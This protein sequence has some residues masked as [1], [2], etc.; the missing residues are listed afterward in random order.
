MFPD[1][2]SE[3]VSFSQD[4]WYDTLK[5]VLAPIMKRHLVDIT[6]EGRENIPSHGPALLVINHRTTTD[7]FILGAIV[8]RRIHFVVAAFMSRL[9]LTARVVKGTGQIMLP[10]S[11]GGGS[12]KLIEKAKRLLLRGRL[13]GVFPEG[14]D[15]FVNASAPGTVSPFHSSF[16]HL[17][18]GMKI[19]DLP[20]V[21][22]AVTGEE[23]EV[24]IELPKVAMRALD[25][26]WK[27]NSVKAT[28]FRQAH[29]RIGKPLAFDNFY[30]L[31]E[32][33]YDEAVKRIV[34]V[35]HDEVLALAAAPTTLSRRVPS[36]KALT[37]HFDETDL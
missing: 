11:K 13:V 1:F 16:A 7:P 36:K 15:N 35:V 12:K 26:T 23:E 20:V 32:A 29:V 5:T 4:L 2:R 34:S 28:I 37:L 22:I 17:L 9:P 33:R 31:P 25:P 30:D 8:P 21:P 24:V 14:V 19:P 27:H 18:M 6:Y 10:V 3:M